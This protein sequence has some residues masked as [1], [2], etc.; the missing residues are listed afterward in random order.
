M[1]VIFLTVLVWAAAPT[2]VWKGVYTEAQAA[3][4]QSAYTASC[5][6][7][8]QPNLTGYGGL[9]VGEK[10]M[11]HWREDNVGNFY[12]LMKVSMPR[13]APDSLGDKA[14]LEIMAFILQQNGFPDG[15][16]ELTLPVLNNIQI[17][18]Q[19]GPQTSP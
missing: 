13:G 1:P 8:H 19:D 14:Y 15:N 16:V 18:G 2:S 3:R 11:E 4:G 9:L 5:S 17:E 12:Q 7:C 6:G 10:F